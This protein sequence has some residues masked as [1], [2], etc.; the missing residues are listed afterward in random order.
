[1]QVAPWQEDSVLQ[2]YYTMLFHKA[3]ST[4]TKRFAPACQKLDWRGDCSNLKLA[5]DQR[6]GSKPIGEP[7]WRCT[8]GSGRLKFALSISQPNQL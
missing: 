8:R 6:L 1:M 2:S 7:F 5:E 3:R 4:R